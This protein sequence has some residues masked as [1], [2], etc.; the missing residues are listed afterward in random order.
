M[1]T[2]ETLGLFVNT[3]TFDHKYS[4]YKREHFPWAIQMKLSKKPE[5]FHELYIAFLKSTSYVQHLEK[6]D[7]AHSST[8]SDVIDSEWSCYLN[9]S[10]D[11]F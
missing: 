5:I 11:L 9:V 7:E 3:L 10:R 6:K 2:A 8:I 1:A 4:C